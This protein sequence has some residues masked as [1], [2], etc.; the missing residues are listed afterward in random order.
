MCSYEVIDNGRFTIRPHRRLFRADNVGDFGTGICNQVGRSHLKLQSAHTGAHI[1]QILLQGRGV[2]IGGEWLF[3]P[4][5]GTTAADIAGEAEQFLHRNK[6]GFL[7]P[8]HFGS[9]LEVYL[10]IAGHN[11]HEIVASAGAFAAE[12]ECL[13]HLIDIFAERLG[14]VGGR[15]VVFVN[16]IRHKPIS[17]AGTVEKP[18]GVGLFRRI[19]FAFLAHILL[20]TCIRGKV[21]KILNK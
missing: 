10:G 4:H 19:S 12:H 7:H 2:E 9:L 20:Y 14:Y 6:V 16:L 15:E 11:T 1:Y 8:G 18:C 13:E 21:T 17:H 3:H 5:G